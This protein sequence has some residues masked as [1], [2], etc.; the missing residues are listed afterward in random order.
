MSSKRAQSWQPEPS[1]WLVF[2]T[3]TQV[4][5]RPV[6]LYVLLQFPSLYAYGFFFV[7]GTVPNESEVKK[8]LGSGAKKDG[9]WPRLLSVPKS[10]PAEPAL[11]KIAD[12][13]GVVVETRTVKEIEP[14]ARPFKEEFARFAFSPSGL[15]GSNL[16]DDVPEEDRVSAEAA[17]PDSFDP[18][19]CASGQKYKFCCKKIFRE[20][21]LAMGAAQDGRL[22]EALKWMDTART[23]AGE[24]GEVLCR[25]GIVHSYF[26]GREAEKYFE[27]CAR[28]FPNHPRLNYI[29]GIQKKEAGDFKR[30]ITS[31]QRAIEHY[32]PT[33]KYH[34]NETW[35]NLGSAYYENKQYSEAKAAWEQ[36]LIL[37]PSD[38]VAK[39]NLIEF[40]YTN[41]DLPEELRRPSLFVERF[42]NAGRRK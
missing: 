32:P 2:R 41:T 29:L 11:R 16:R 10:D 8:L 9:R 6:D 35:S 42:L 33:D 36:A 19:P 4:Q 31:Y 39:D 21:T 40:I 12:K 28:L 1:Q 14:F 25:F 30:A 7:E 20:I 15:I 17:L 3:D 34:L 5:N 37:L 24:T 18:C 23:I 27:R 22:N 26:D 38:R 13:H